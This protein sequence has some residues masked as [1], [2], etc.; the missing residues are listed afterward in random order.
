MT[1]NSMTNEAA[2]LP[3][4]SGALHP[5]NDEGFAQA[6]PLELA[7][8]MYARCA[9][10]PA[11]RTFDQDDLLALKVIPADDLALL[12][13]C[14]NQLTRQGLLKVYKRDG[15]VCWKVVKKEEAAK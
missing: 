1:A 11:D 2:Y 13:D 15:R 6:S 7:K 3:Q 14:V 10:Q 9:N 12:L 4:V 5:D 8:F